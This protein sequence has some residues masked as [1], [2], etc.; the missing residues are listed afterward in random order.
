MAKRKDNENNSTEEKEADD[1]SSESEVSD[2]ED[3]DLIL[4]GVLIRNPDVSDS[5]DESS[6]EDEDEKQNILS[7]INS[8]R[9]YRR[10][11]RRNLGKDL[12]L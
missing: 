10:E 2:E 1:I 11:R 12:I 5:D 6:S 9:N 7:P 8:N 3:E 4:E